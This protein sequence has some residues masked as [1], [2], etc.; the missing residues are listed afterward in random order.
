MRMS[1]PQIE[2]DD[3]TAIVRES[4]AVQSNDEKAAHV[5][6][7]V[8]TPPGSPAL[9]LQLDFEP[10]SDHH[11][12]I[13]DLLCFHDRTFVHAAYRTILKRSPD[14]TEFYRELKRLRSGN[15]NKIDLL[16]G[17]RFSA[18]GRAKKVQLDGLLVP[19]LVRRLGQ[20]PV[21]GYGIRLG[22]A[23]LRLPN[24]IRDQRQFSSHV[25]AQ[26]E[27]IAD[28]VNV[29]S[30]R[31]TESHHEVA[32][33]SEA[34]SQHANTF[35]A[36]QSELERITDS[37]FS[38]LD[39]RLDV[40]ET[41]SSEQL[42]ALRAQIGNLLAQL[43]KERM[44]RQTALSQLLSEQQE[45]LSTTRNE[46][47]SKQSE[48]HSEIARLQLQLQHTRSQI[49]IH[50]ESIR[51]LSSSDRS[52]SPTIQQEVV[53]AHHLDAFYAELEDRFRGTRK[54]IK[55]RFQVYLPYINESA[56]VVDLGCGRGEWLE[57]LSEAGIEAHGV[58]TNRIQVEECRARGLN[59]SEEDF[60]VHLRGLADGSA[61]AV[62]G[63]HIIEHVS[64]DAL[65]TLVSE[66]MRVLRPGGV[67]IFETPN[68]E[69]VLVG[70]RYFYL[71]PTHRHPLPSEL[72]EF[73]LASRGFD[74]IEIL[75]LH[76]WDSAKLAGEDE[77]T[78]RFN[79]Y[80][81][82]PMDYAIVGRKVSA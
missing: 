36:Q 45:L 67:V 74:K 35:A 29:L 82:G 3:L 33:L 7:A 70:S 32:R 80:F 58:D 26:H 12:H 79:T 51:V 13:N 20:V 25:L 59:I 73:L 30:T 61:G 60:L 43:E 62:T 81:Y 76:P 2:I 66:V 5:A 14:E 46:M 34:L 24:L 50:D 48:L 56:A 10:R 4:M 38:Q 19:A 11:Y 75:N 6:A 21:I 57:L 8:P 37:R 17:L 27:Q 64:L 1:S 49:T 40:F 31:I 71:D 44:E 28:F 22:I 42:E 55:E 16:A 47:E 78:A 63:F 54:E 23:F 39:Q 52:V 15:L 53:D 69:N 68:P 9:K 72:M 65:I 77:L 18:E 41:N